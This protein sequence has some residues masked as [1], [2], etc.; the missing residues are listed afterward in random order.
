MTRPE[1]RWL[2]RL[3]VDEAHFRQIRE[4]GGTHGLRDENALESAL[5]RPR[6]RWHY[7]QDAMLADLAAAY[8]FGL[9]KNH[10]YVDGNKRIA[11]VVMVA[12]LARNGVDL[13]ATNHDAFSVV[14]SV[15]AGQ[16]SEGELSAWVQDHV[17]QRAI[18][19]RTARVM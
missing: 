6:Q 7:D 10:A 4:H 14:T 11:L 5:G 9:A 2:G 16:T 1:P 18:E 13:M 12:F 8:G 19:R 3:A 17:E 15:A